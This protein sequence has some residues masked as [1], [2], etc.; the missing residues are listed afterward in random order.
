MCVW[1]SSKI[2]T[3]SKSSC[4]SISRVSDSTSSHG[5]IG[6]TGETEMRLMKH[7]TGDGSGEAL[8]MLEILDDYSMGVYSCCG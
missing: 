3:W 4:T 8:E 5:G 1:P 2:I 7:P 6:L